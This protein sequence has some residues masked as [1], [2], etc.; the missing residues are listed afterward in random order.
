LFLHN[1]TSPKLMR[2]DQFTDMLKSSG[3][4]SFVLKHSNDIL[5]D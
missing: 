5:T 3:I 4:S 1:D 2:G